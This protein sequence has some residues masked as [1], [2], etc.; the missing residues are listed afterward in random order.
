MK[1][2]QNAGQMLAEVV[3]AI[4]LLALILVGMSELLSR[5]T[6]NIRL[7]KQKD[8]AA[9]A[10]EARLSYLRQER[11]KD[12]AYFFA[13]VVHNLDS[14][15]FTACTTP[16][17]PFVAE[18]NFSCTERYSDVVSGVLVEVKAS[19]TN[20]T[21]NDTSVTLSRILEND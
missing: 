13:S 15:T 4:G 18:Y 11:D 8:E 19:W 6:A 10:V 7:N 17:W 3:I 2:R 14:G 12:S 21:T 5:S 20:K 9:R 16:V 1:Q